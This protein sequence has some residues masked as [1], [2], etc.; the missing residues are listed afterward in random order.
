MASQYLANKSMIEA[1]SAAHGVAAFFVWQP[2]SFYNYDRR[3]H[4]FADT[5]E[6]HVQAGYAHMAELAGEGQ[7]GEDFLWLAD[8]Q[9]G[10]EEPLYVDQAHYS[11]R[12][13]RL[14]ATEIGDWLIG[15]GALDESGASG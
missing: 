4:L 1:I 12:M 3:H 14:I 11:G 10:M 2:V 9:V 8:L 13:S 6:P 15:Q 5:D 7:L